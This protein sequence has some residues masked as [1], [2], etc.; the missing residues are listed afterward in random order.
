MNI[1]KLDQD[2]SATGQLQP[3]Q[4][5]EVA[6]AGFRSVL[7]ARPDHEEPGQPSFAAIEAAARQS[8]I[9]SR[10]HSHFRRH[11]GGGADPHGGSPEQPADADAGLLPLRRTGGVAL[12]RGAASYAQ[13]RIGVAMTAEVTY[14]SDV[15][16]VWA[17]V[18]Q[19]RLDAVRQTF[20]DLTIRHRFV[21]VFGN[22]PGKVG[23]AW[24]DR[25]GFLGYARHVRSVA[26]R[27]PHVTIGQGRHGQAVQPA[28]S[29]RPHLFLSALRQWEAETCSRVRTDR[30]F[31]ARAC[32]RFGGR[33]SPMARI[34]PISAYSRALVEPFGVDVPGG[35]GACARWL[36]VR[37][38]VQGLPRTPRG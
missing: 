9:E 37:C 26:D 29:A 3:D 5:V 18:G 25:G 19:A 15:L 16:C 12:W 22:V 14:F 7:C 38:A 32:G 6:A 27:F 20:P 4:L 8:G 34:S 17:Y 33:F 23:G 31:E 2:F 35:V 30:S 1:R 24:K 10:A 36:G 13:L 11:R 28:S 21:S